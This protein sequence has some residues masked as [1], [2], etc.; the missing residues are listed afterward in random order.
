M[1]DGVGFDPYLGLYH[2]ID[3]GR[4]SLALDMVELF[5]HAL[6]DRLMLRLFNLRMLGEADFDTVAHG[7]VYLS[8]SGKKT[9][10]EQYEDLAGS[11]RGEADL[12]AKK[13][14]REYFRLQVNILQKT[15]TENEDFCYVCPQSDEENN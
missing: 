12:K 5:R 3:Y 7:G 14:F 11:Y 4:P 6:V 1:L 8:N 10:F 2:E 9:F 15:M 13:G